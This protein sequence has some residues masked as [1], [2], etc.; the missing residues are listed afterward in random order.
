[1]GDPNPE[2]SMRRLLPLAFLPLMACTDTSSLTDVLPDDRLLVELDDDGASTARG[3]LGEWSAF[4]VETARTTTTVN[5]FIGSVLTLVD[6]VIRMRPSEVDRDGGRASWGPYR[7]TL[8]PVSV[9]L[10]VERQADGSH[11]WWFDQWPKD[12]NE[13]EAVPVVLGEVDPGATRRASTGR[14]TIDYTTMA[15]D[16]PLVEYL[17]TFEADYQLDPDGAAAVAS[18]REFA[19]RS[20]PLALIDADYDFAQVRG[21]EGRMDFGW[22]GVEPQSGLDARWALRSRW[23]ADGQGRG[24]ATVRLEDESAPSLTA[25]ECWS[26]RFHLVWEESSWEGS[27]GDP[28][29]CAF[30]EASWPE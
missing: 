2:P 22:A 28:S 17:G 10:T 6:T 20:A 11:L 4:Y 7:D 21:G 26:D 12:G 9:R 24:D 16:N 23:L 1:M 14:F 29:A 27:Q 30:A 8:S 15:E 25:S 3:T 18:V 5:G 19:H 13:D